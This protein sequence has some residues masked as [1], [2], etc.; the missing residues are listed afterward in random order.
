MQSI[1]NTDDSSIF[2][3]NKWVFFLV[4]CLATLFLLVVKKTFIED[5][6]AAFEVL[7]SRGEMGVFHAINALQYFSI[8]LI[9][10]LKFTIISFVIWVGS[11]MFGYKITYAQIWQV[12][13]IAE[14]IFLIPEMLKIIWFL[15]IDMDPNL[16]EI[17][18][19]YP[20]SLMH[21]ADPYEIDSR[22]FYPLKAL[23]IFE[24]VYWFVL[25]EGVHHMAG[26]QKNIAYAIVFSSYVL[27]FLLWLGF[28]L[29][30]YK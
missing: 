5:Q 28:Y 12:V 10:L 19:F 26:K 29:L 24:I 2:D 13:V 21:L 27:F 4:L 3:T 30:V 6:T 16:F 23:N 25:V 22:W 17:R 14:A 7:E 1:E 18:S 20:L 9:Y 11:F 8:P 15:F